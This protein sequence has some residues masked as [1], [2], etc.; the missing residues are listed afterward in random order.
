MTNKVLAHNAVLK[1]KVVKWVKVVLKACPKVVSKAVAHKW[2]ACKVLHPK[3]FHQNNSR[4]SSPL[5]IRTAIACSPWKNSKQP[6]SPF[7]Q[8]K[9]VKDKWVKWDK[10]VHKACKAVKWVKAVNKAVK[11]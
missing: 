5:L 6:S 11:A 1:L 2:V 7:V 8:N 10:V 4:K 9:V 3:A